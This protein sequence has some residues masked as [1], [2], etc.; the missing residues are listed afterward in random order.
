MSDIICAHCG[1]PWEAYAVFHDFDDDDK[2]LFLAGRGCPSCYGQ[3]PPPGDFRRAWAD[4]LIEATD[5]PDSVLDNI[6][7]C[8]GKDELP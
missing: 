3:R 8:L 4:S 7:N 1:E 5:D 6:M 2:E